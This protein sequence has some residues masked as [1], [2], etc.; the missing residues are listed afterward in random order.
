[1]LIY[2]GISQQRGRTKMDIY[3]KIEVSNIAVVNVTFRRANFL[4]NEGRVVVDI[5]TYDFA[6]H[7]ANDVVVGFYRNGVYEIH[8]FY[9][10]YDFKPAKQSEVEYDV[11]VYEYELSIPFEKTSPGEDFTG[12][13]LICGQADDEFSFT[14]EQFEP[15]LQ[16]TYETINSTQDLLIGK[17]AQ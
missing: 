15:D 16:K 13:R 11:S 17:N 3:P 12:R 1:M 8:Y 4:Y 10:D 9:H 7:L 14:F 6:G 2:M 5:G